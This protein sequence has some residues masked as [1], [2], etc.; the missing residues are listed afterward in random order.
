M[1]IGRPLFAGALLMSLL[2][3]APPP[4][5]PLDCALLMLKRSALGVQL[6][7]ALIAPG[8]TRVFPVKLDGE[9]IAPVLPWG[10]GQS[11][12]LSDLAETRFLIVRCVGDTL[13]VAVR[14]PDGRSRDLPPVAADRV[15]NT[16]LRVS[17]QGPDGL[18]AVFR[19]RASGI[20]PDTIGPLLDAFGGQL[21]PTASSYLITTEVIPIARAAR[22]T[23]SAPL[24]FQNGHFFSNARLGD[25][26]SGRLVLDLAAERTVVGRATVP[27]GLAIRPL[28]GTEHSTAG[29]R[30]VTGELGGAGGPVGGYLGR[31]IL[32]QLIWGGITVTALE[33]DVVDSLPAVGGQPVIGILGLDI[34]RRAPGVT[35]T[36]G[37]TPTISLG[38][39]TTAAGGA[40]VA[41]S[42]VS[43]HL[44][45]RGRIGGLAVPL[46]LDS[47]A[48]TS[49]LTWA[50]AADPAV[51]V[52]STPGPTVVGLDNRPLATRSGIVSGLWLG[53]LTIASV[54]VNVADLPVFRQMGVS[55]PAVGLLGTDFLRRFERVEVDWARQ[56]LRIQ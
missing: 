22:S 44:F 33:V 50:A 34:L 53:N 43:G 13:H 3:L 51:Q 26:S 17:V 38:T 4:P 32:P 12:D 46:I 40:I 10:A 1:P 35:L 36:F 37:A 6:E 52:D 20:E 7:R 39:P 45:V 56:T 11:G 47:G 14:T 16:E 8:S 23:G 41:F 30:S 55:E 25:G 29:A 27:A 42:F 18:R 54:R 5:A 24:T 48:P 49:Y 21:S 19:A 28:T 31:A 9:N 2:T 15:A